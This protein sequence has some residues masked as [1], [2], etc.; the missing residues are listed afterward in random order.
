MYLEHR[1]VAL[2]S[3]T[4]VFGVFTSFV[5]LGSTVRY[6]YGF[7]IL[8]TMGVIFVYLVLILAL[9]RWSNR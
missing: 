1:I 4:L 8:V 7:I 5:A 3:A 9:I 2:L 6:I